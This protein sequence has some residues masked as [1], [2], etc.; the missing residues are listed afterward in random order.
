MGMLQDRSYDMFSTRD[1]R[2]SGAILI[3]RDRELLRL[4]MDSW[5]ENTSIVDEI[6]RVEV[7]I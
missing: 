4:I 2:A 7:G 3:L 5:A 1:L 6:E